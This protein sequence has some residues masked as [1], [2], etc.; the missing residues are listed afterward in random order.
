MDYLVIQQ[1]GSETIVARFRKQR[2]MLLFV[3]ASRQPLVENQSL[4]DQL[5]ELGDQENEESRIILAVPSGDLFLR[6]L[7]V[8]L[9]D[10]RKLREIL[11]LE[12]KGETALDTD[13]LIFD[14]I[15]LENGNVLAVWGRRPG[16]VEAIEQLAAQKLEP[17][18]VTCSPFTWQSIIPAD[19]ND[20]T[21]TAI[22]DGDSLALF[23]GA[24]PVFFRALTGEDRGAEVTRTLAALEIGRKIT[25][26]HL[27]THGMLARQEGT[28]PPSAEPLPISGILAEAFGGEEDVAR[29]LAGAFA[30]ATTCCFGDPVN[31]RNGSLA[32]TRERDKMLKKLRL[33]AILA[34]VFVTLLFA[35]VGLRYYL[36]KQD[37][38][39][40][41]ASIKTIYRELFPNRKKAVDEVAELRSEIK[42]LGAG[43]SS[44]SVLR[45][46]KKLAEA[47]T[48]GV[49]GFFETDIDGNQVRLKG[50][51]RS[52]QAVNDFKTKTTTAFSDAEV[53]EIKSRPD[54]TVSF[55]FRGTLKGEGK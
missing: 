17:E 32:Y 24:T 19:T 50:D 43:T 7:T 26:D 9:M 44:G 35:Q 5:P 42:R 52:I 41:N 48:D 8:P 47:K 33:T 36:I 16:M 34:A 23:R 21:F 15:I 14:A 1:T 55:Q 11:P 39:S 37:L 13:D 12:L 54:G 49:T 3:G 45:I 6:E 2:K 40:L 27:Y 29:E 38:G 31:F 10:R 46:L 28:A 22:S 20:D 25:V 30:V 4:T 53:S 18:F 51:A